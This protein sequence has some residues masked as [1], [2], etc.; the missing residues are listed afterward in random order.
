[1]NI[2]YLRTFQEIVRL[3]SF[4]E[5]AKKLGISQPAVTFQIQKLEQELG[6]RLI[7]RSQRTITLTPAGQ[8]LL[9]FA[10]SVGAE[11]EILQHDLE[12]L[13]DKVTGELRIAAS[14]IP[15]EYLLPT[16]LAKFKHRYP[17]VK[18]RVDVSDSLMVIS[19]VSDSTYDIGFCGIAPEGKDTTSFKI[20][21][22]EIVLIVPP[23][24]PFVSKRTV[25]PEEL[26]GESFIF[27]EPTS[28]TQQNLEKLLEKA[29]LN[30]K[31]W[32]PNLVLGSTQSVV[33]AVAADAGV[34]FVSNLAIK[35]C[36]AQGVVR[37]V[38]VRGLQLRRDFFCVYRQERI[39]SRLLEVFIDFIRTEALEH[40]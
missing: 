31:E 23:G 29:G 33:A 21:S 12:Q 22:D 24:H 8:R 6:A 14:T 16:L 34:A 19:Q 32:T 4:S 39:I 15:G 35:Q 36:T 25:K 40:G 38:N 30:I 2:E 1:M 10:E 26:T 11:R 13:Q 28:G 27:R 3:G 17:A 37:Q 9:K 20:A 18:I 5:V 7:D